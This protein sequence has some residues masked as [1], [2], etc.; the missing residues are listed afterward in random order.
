M[1]RRLA[2]KI[3]DR[4]LYEAQFPNFKGTLRERQTMRMCLSHWEQLPTTL[5]RKFSDVKKDGLIVICVDL[6]NLTS[7]HLEYRK[8]YPNLLGGAII[9]QKSVLWV[10]DVKLVVGGG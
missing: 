3:A 6:H 5:E 9:G 1:S 4:V 7:G 8:G 10:K 2:Y